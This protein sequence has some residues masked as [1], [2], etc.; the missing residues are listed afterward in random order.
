MQSAQIAIKIAQC[1]EAL[2]RADRAEKTL[3]R[4]V[5]TYPKDPTVHV[6]LGDALLAQRRFEDARKAYGEALEVDGTHEPAVLKIAQLMVKEAKVPEAIEYLKGALQANPDAGVLHA[7]LADLNKRMAD[8]SGERSLLKEAEAGYRKALVLE[9]ALVGAQASLSQVLLAL[10]RPEEALEQLESLVQRPDFH[11]D[12]S[13]ELGV[14]KQRL[15]KID[16]A[17]GHFDAALKRTPEDPELLLAAGWAYFEHGDNAKARDLLNKVNALEPKLYH[18]HYAIG[19]VDFAEGQPAAAVQRI[20][21]ALEEDKRNYTYRYW[22]G[23]ALEAQGDKA[24][25]K[26]A[27]AEYDIVVRAM[28]DDASLAEALCD[29]FYRRG[30]MESATFAEWES[31]KKDFQAALK[32]DADRPEIWFALAKVQEMSNELKPA[33][34]S[35]K[36][37]TRLQRDLAAAYDLAAGIHLRSRPADKRAAQKMSELAIKHDPSLAAAHFRLCEIHVSSNRGLARKHCEKYLELEPKGLN[38]DT[39]REY[40]R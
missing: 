10:E 15:G 5:E 8:I 38:A 9:P 20:K 21:L 14:A 12:L 29:A 3:T 39:A 19:R 37:A 35:I 40:L 26:A 24:A 27:R 25:A 31:A 4:A 28:R 16:E 36:E 13:Y 34:A 32:C 17:I 18:A 7:G 23:R 11:G 2:N 30:V 6:A 1:H 33:L 22:L